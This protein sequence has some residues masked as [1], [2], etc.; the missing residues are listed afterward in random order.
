MSRPRPP[1]PWPFGERLLVRVV[2]ELGR[3]GLTERYIKDPTA[4][5]SGLCESGRITINPIPET[6]DTVAHELI[7]RL[8]PEWGELRVAQMTR[9]LVRRMTDAQIQQF[10][11]E[12]DARKRVS[13][14]TKIV[15]G[16]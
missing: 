4:I 7:H 13:K 1:K 16:A 14:R 5:T 2:A 11:L 12:Y 10:A 9:A 3:G 6:V 15:E 8:Y